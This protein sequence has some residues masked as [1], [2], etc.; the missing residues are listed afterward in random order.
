MTDVI[1]LP[2]FTKPLLSASKM[3]Q[4]DDTAPAF[5]IGDFGT[6][7]CIINGHLL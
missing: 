7:Y 4:G 2:M 1:W 5:Q 6:F 3:I